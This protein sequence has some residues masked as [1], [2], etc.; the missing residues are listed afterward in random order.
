M[1][2]LNIEQIRGSYIHNDENDTDVKPVARLN[3]KPQLCLQL[4]GKIIVRLPGKI[5]IATSS[6][7]MRRC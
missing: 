4:E 1:D 6:I 2:A 7:R 3:V 5:I